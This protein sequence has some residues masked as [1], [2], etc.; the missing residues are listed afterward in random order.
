MLASAPLSS[1]RCAQAGAGCSGR[2]PMPAM[3]MRGRASS[4]G[5]PVRSQVGASACM[6]GGGCACMHVSVRARVCACVRL[7]RGLHTRKQACPSGRAPRPA[8]PSSLQAASS[9]THAPPL[10][11]PPRVEPH[12]C[13]LTMGDHRP[14]VLLRQPPAPPSGG[15]LF[16]FER[17]REA[18]ERQ[19]SSGG[20]LDRPPRLLSLH[21]GCIIRHTIHMVR[22]TPYDM[23]SSQGDLPTA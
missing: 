19:G 12:G 23:R 5:T 8:R 10:W 15:L 22:H 1:D 16:C 6:Q 14:G 20:A 3:P 21:Q 18:R 4:L 2:S 13:S 7:R 11:T 17:E 9:S